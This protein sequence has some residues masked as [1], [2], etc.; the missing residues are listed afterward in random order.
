MS[1]QW[2]S[3]CGLKTKQCKVFWEGQSIPKEKKKG[4]NM[5]AVDRDLG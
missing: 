4:K 3:A 2:D 1:S 5:Q